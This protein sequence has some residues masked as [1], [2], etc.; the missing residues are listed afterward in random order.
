VKNLK[1]SL[2]KMRKDPVLFVEGMLGAK[3]DKWQVEVMKAVAEH[4]RGI[5]IRS[6]HGV[7]KTSCLSWLALWFISTHYHA[8]V[9]VTAPYV[10]PAT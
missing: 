7:G 10:C 9:V 5:S 4:H 1:S 2:R 8:K 6:G 3:P